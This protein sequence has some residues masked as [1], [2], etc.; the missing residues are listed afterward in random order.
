MRASRPLSLDS[1]LPIIVVQFLEVNGE[2]QKLHHNAS[3]L[4]QSK[5]VQVLHASVRLW[6]T[7]VLAWLTA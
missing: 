3:V 5:P 4:K 2:Q 7:N 1:E 6:V